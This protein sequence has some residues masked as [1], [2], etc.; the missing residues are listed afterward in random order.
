[1]ADA[2]RAIHGRGPKVADRI[3]RETIQMLAERGYGFSVDEVAARAGVHKTTIYR[4]WKSKPGL[5]A[6]AME[7]VAQTEIVVPG[8]LDPLT[9]VE[10]L[11]VM[12]A[13]TLRADSSRAALRA[14]MSAAAEDPE[15][16]PVARAFFATRYR[17]A[18]TLIEAARD[19]GQVRADVD[20]LLVWEAMVNP[21]H[22]R[23]ITGVPADDD[24]ARALVGL[25]LGGCL[26]A[27]RD[28]DH[29]PVG[30]A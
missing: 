27:R 2:P 30:D 19:A 29:H 3:L 16:L 20:P 1:M 21:L 11:A 13:T 12:V 10:S 17:V 6:A 7:A 26:A 5:V 9:A 28:D 23:A 24:T 15:L 22:L 25:V 8:D 18:T 4:R 14:L